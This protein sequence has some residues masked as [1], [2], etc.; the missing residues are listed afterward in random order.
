[1]NE[2]ADSPVAVAPQV[3]RPGIAGLFLITFTGFWTFGWLLREPGMLQGL[4]YMRYYF[5]NADWLRRSL[6]AGE[7]P[8]WNPCVG[9]GRPFLADMQTGVLYPPSWLHLLLGVPVATI[10]LVW[11]HQIWCALGAFL[12]ARRLGCTCAIAWGVAVVFVVAPSLSVRFISGQILFGAGLCYLPGL[13]WLL[14]RLLDR[15]SLRRAGWLAAVS[16]LQF[17]SGHPQCYWL[18]HVGLGVFTLAWTAGEGWRT[19]LLAAGRLTGAMLLGLALAAPVLLPFVEFVTESD[20]A[21][22]SAVLS[23]QGA[24]VLGDWLG[25]VVPPS[26]SFMPDIEWQILVG[27]PVL[28]MALAALRRWREERAVRALFIL[29]VVAALLASSLPEWLHHL[30]AAGLPGFAVFRLHARLSVL[31]VLALFLLAGGWLSRTRAPRWLGLAGVG[32]T[33]LSLVIALP[34]LKRWYVMP[35]SYP[36]EPYMAGLVRELQRDDPARVPPRINISAR[37][38]R[39]N[40]GMLMGYSTFNGYV[41][42]YPGRVW[43]YVHAAAGLPPPPTINTFPD[44]QIFERDPFIYPSM[45]LVAGFDTRTREM[46]LN[47][48]PDPRAYLCFAAKEAGSWPEAVR[49]MVAG[50]DFHAT[51]LVESPVS[52]LDGNGQG[53]ARITAFAN[54]RVTVRA[55]STTRA[56][57]VIAEAW[58]PGWEAEVN[59]LPARAFP[60]NG[61]MRG[62]VVPAGQSEVVWRYRSRWFGAG[63]AVGAAALIVLMIAL[64]RKESARTA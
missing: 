57:L 16:A 4:D 22:I 8:W 34:G 21:K 7:L 62:V 54:E 56:I 27:A 31:V 10:V 30:V 14:L 55:E 58:Y 2:P 19:L 33:V 6:L 50:H 13:F 60:V 28:L 29:A 40:S 11:L 44:V 51:A 9:L 39:E 38:V 36:F 20:R 35:A 25:L 18:T 41:S 43:Q 47:P 52:G 32:L 59:G 26:E 45:N 23:T 24:M 5:F 17:L 37:R 46:R 1:M 12:L 48:T 15:P 42:L 64:T 49:R 63:C 61:W 53:S 3:V